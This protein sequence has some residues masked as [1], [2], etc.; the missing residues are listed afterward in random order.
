MIRRDTGMT[1][2]LAQPSR[3]SR[4]SASQRTHAL[5]CSDPNRLLSALGTLSPAD[6]AH[7]S[8]LARLARRRATLPASI[9]F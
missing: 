4:R 5:A 8:G 9:T 6:Q 3:A 7:L 2:H 1:V